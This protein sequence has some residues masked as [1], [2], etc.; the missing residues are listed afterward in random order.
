VRTTMPFK[1]RF[2]CT[3]GC[4]EAA[5]LL[6]L[7]LPAASQVQRF[8]KSSMNEHNLPSL[9]VLDEAVPFAQ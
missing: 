6:S 8:S 2:P 4:S 7:N 5:R 1:I 9:V 3:V